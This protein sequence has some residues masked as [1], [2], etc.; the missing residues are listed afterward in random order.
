MALGGHIISKRIYIV[1]SQWRA[2]ML[3]HGNIKLVLKLIE[4]SGRVVMRIEDHGSFTVKAETG[5]KVSFFVPC[6]VQCF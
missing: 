1:F 4:F 6:I 2:W 5:I 3:Y